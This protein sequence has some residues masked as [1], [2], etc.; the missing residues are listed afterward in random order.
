MDI[1][2]L[3]DRLRRD[4]RVV[5]IEKNARAEPCRPISRRTPALVVMDVSFI[6]V[7][8]ILPA[9]GAVFGS[10]PAPPGPPFPLLL[11]LIKPQFEAGKGQVGKKGVIRD[12]ALHAEIL[13]RIVGEAASLGFALEG[14]VRCAT[15][16]RR[17]TR[18][19]SP[20][21][22]RGAWNRPAK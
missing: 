19:S 10:A 21:S 12:P 8:K 14:L 16:G 22:R 7:T 2:Q 15:R 1:R 18:N 9:L 17:A 13:T 20:A 5:T 4:P 11:S 6:S 3:D